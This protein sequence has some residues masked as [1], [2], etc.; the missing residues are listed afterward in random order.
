MLKLMRQARV[1]REV[2]LRTVISGG[3]TVGTE[4][5]AWGRERLGLDINEIY[6]QTECN[7]VLGPCARAHGGA[8]RLVGASLARAMSSA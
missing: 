5:L 4:L 2:S 3:E 6:G 1:P 7:L 8:A